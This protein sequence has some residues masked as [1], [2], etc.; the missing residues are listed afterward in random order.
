[1]Q[2]WALILATIRETIEKKIF[3]INLLLSALVIAVVASISFNDQGIEVLFGWRTIEEPSLST[4]NPFY[5][6]L[7]SMLLSG[8]FV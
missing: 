6:G 5:R 8:L 7:I 4:A 2:I 3:W 1:M